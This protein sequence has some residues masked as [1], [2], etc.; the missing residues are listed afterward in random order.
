M[1]PEIVNYRDYKSVDNEKF[2]AHI[3]IFDFGA[4]DVE[5]FKYRIACVSNKHT[6]IFM[7]MNLHE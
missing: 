1:P 6:P 5:D 3:Y 4:S 2:R 7:E